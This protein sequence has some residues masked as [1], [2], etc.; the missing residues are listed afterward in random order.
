MG[1]RRIA[2]T[3]F[4]IAGLALL[5]AGCEKDTPAVQGPDI[6]ESTL[7]VNEFIHE[8]MSTYYL[9]NNEMPDVDYEKQT[10]PN[11]YFD[12]LLYKPIDRWSFITDDYLTLAKSYEGI[13]ESM[14]HSFILYR[15]TNSSNDIFGVIQFVYPNSPA[16]E[17]G[18]SRGDLFTAIDG[19]DLTID[20]YITLLEKK[21]YTLTVA[22]AQDGVVVPIKDIKLTAREIT[23][24]PILLYDT[25]NIDG[26]VIGY[27]VYKNFFDNYNDSLKTA[28]QWFKSVGVDELVL[29]LRYNNGG[30]ISSMQYLASLIAPNQQISRKDIIIRTMYNSILTGYYSSQGYSSTTNFKDLGVTLNLGRIY[31]LTGTNTASAS[32]A[33]IV[34]LEPYMEVVT[35]GSQTHGKYTGAFLINDETNKHNWAIQP[36]VMKY[37]NSI[38]F[39]DFYNG[40]TVNFQGEDDL[41]NRLGDPKEGLLALAIE[42]ITGVPAPI[43]IK[44]A[45]AGLI[46][47]P[48]ETYD[49]N[50]VRRDIPAL[51]ERPEINETD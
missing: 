2:Q 38:G 27:M 3:Y 26:T 18:L 16:S 35:L 50:K 8:N 5:F 19:T 33:L 41:F 39:T 43:A 47:V 29:D 25:L 51:Q 36:I 46:G 10:D 48:V 42:K 22:K 23:E 15:Y 7:I 32:E 14:G 12:T 9:W 44:S 11:K 21:S 6:P 17:A 31:I 20:N 28:Y 1:T 37:A 30:A 49:G 34:G 45:R 24:N 40:L 13:E 4:L